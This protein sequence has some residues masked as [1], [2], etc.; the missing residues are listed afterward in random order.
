MEPQKKKSKAEKRA[1]EEER[2]SEEPDFAIQPS[3]EVAKIDTSK[4]PLLLKNYDLLHIRT[5]HY[6]V[7]LKNSLPD[8][9]LIV[10]AAYTQWYE[11][12][13]TEHPRVHSLWSYQPR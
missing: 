4:W 10:M 3:N 11:S 12:T 6:T 13:A 9:S 1:R 7:C 2:Q 5:G 8:F